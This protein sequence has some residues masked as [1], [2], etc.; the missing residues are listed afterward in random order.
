MAPR[1]PETADG[2]R[3]AQPSLDAPR[4]EVAA[5]LE[6]YCDL[7]RRGH[8]DQEIGEITVWPA[9]IT[10]WPEP[11]CNQLLEEAIRRGMIDTDDNRDVAFR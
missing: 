11:Y 9:K 6:Q 7:R 3:K 10:V 1:R 4:P 5:M 2:S 8:D